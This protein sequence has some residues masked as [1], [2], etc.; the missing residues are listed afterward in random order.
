MQVQL[1][2]KRRD[3]NFEAI[4][5]IEEALEGYHPQYG[6]GSMSCAVYDTAWVSLVTKN[7][8]GKKQWLFPECFQYLLDTQKEDGSW[9]PA[10]TG[11]Q[12][13]PILNTAASLLSLRR[14][15]VESLQLCCDTS[16]ETR[17]KTA[18][19]SLRSQLSE[20]CVSRTTHVGFEVIV[21]TLL[22]LLEKEDQSTVFDFPGRAELERISA[23]KFSKLKPELLYGP[24]KLTALHSLEAFI[25][26]IDFDQ[27]AHHKTH[28]SMMGSPSSTAAY[29]MNVSQWDDEAEDYLR[30]VIKSGSGQGNGAMPS[31]YPSTHFEYT[32]ILSTL[33]RSGFTASDLES[34]ALEEMVQR[35][36]CAFLEE[37][38]MIGFAP[39]LVPDIDDTAKG[40][41][42]LNKLGRPASPEK[43][44]ERFE[45]ESHFRTYPLERDPSFSANCNALSAFLCQP[46]VSRYTTQ[47]VKAVRFL[48]DYAWKSDGKIKD[49]WNLS[50]LYSSLLLAETLVDLLVLVEQD[51]LTELLGQELQSKVIIILFRTCF[52]TLL[53]QRADGSWN[54]SIEETAYGVLILC[55]ARRVCFIHD[56]RIEIDSSIRSGVAFIESIP[57]RPL[58]Y[59]WVEKVTYASPLLSQCYIVAAMKASSSEVGMRVG[60]SLRVKVSQITIQR[61]VK[62]LKKTGLF[63]SIP[64]WEIYG[65]M[66]EAILFQPLVQ[67]CNPNIFPSQVMGQSK[68][69]D[70]IPLTWTSCS[71]RSR[72]F[73]SASFIYDMIIISFLNYQA[74]EFMESIAEPIFLGRTAELRDLIDR[75]I[76]EQGTI[77]RDVGP[78]IPDMTAAYINGCESSKVQKGEHKMLDSE[79]QQIF[80]TLSQFIAH[81]LHHPSVLPASPWDREC[82]KRELRTFLLAHATQ[83]E[84][85][86]RFIQFRREERTYTTA[87]E[88]FFR[89]VNTTSADHTSCPYS[90]AFVGCLLSTLKGGGESFDTVDTKYL[91][92]SLCRHLSTMCRMYNDHGSVRRD[93]AEGNLNSINFPEF[94]RVR[95]TLSDLTDVKKEALFRL[96][97]Y[98]RSC[99]NQALNRLVSESTS[100][101][102][103]SPGEKERNERQMAIWKMFCDVTDLY[104]QIYVVR[105]I[106]NQGVS[107]AGNGSKR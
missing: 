39:D 7:I 95:T 67:I 25:G 26:K 84:D 3:L 73:V 60:T 6:S 58:N 96:A 63:S 45:A 79:S 40:I 51:G 27:V 66:I 36:A 30:H 17:I 32:W 103:R 9:G 52:R 86:A 75:A 98:E 31:A 24:T 15:S 107:R 50:Y 106:T 64:D 70:L 82:V 18:T 37:D 61:Y 54:Q 62:L 41:I 29:L 69:L 97:E 78:C 19:L 65:S 57:V 83:A 12:I 80:A 81:V 16:L 100:P 5:L 14:H 48:C 93:N 105:D 47:I 10:D 2:S 59:I 4:S 34:P 11:S 74:D 46:D 44:V 55:E 13:D 72:V 35:L 88:S 76:F 28:G 21:P 68:Y 87:T 22:K 20:W 23:I 77:N 102:G 91:S 53:D 1:P 71:N 42:S 99:V 90:F 56:L 101:D 92:A 43:I 89:W 49:K 94:Q 85:N 8:E 38:G 104:G 33:L